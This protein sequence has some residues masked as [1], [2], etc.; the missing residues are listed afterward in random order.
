MQSKE[1]RVGIPSSFPSFLPAFWQSFNRCLL[2]PPEGGFVGD[3][4]IT[5]T[6]FL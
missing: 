6:P 3:T 2:Q 1:L 4:V 5:G